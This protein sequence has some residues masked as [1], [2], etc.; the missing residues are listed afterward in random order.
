[1]YEWI[2]I[3][4]E[5]SQRKARTGEKPEHK[6]EHMRILSQQETPIWPGAAVYEPLT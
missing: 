4:R 5:P 6:Q 2:Q 3:R 1:M